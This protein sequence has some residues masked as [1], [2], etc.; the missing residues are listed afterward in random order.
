MRKLLFLLALPL[1][2]QSPHTVSWTYSYG[3]LKICAPGTPGVTLLCLDHFELVDQAAG[4]LLVSVPIGATPPGPVAYSTPITFGFGAVSIVMV[5][6]D[7]LGGR[8]TSD[9]AKCVLTIR[10]D[11]PGGATVN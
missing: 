3:G 6:K 1:A 8:I 11:P 4:V 5:A 9:P 10:P 2:A 7:A